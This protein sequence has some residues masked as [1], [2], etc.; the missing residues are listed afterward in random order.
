MNHAIRTGLAVLCVATPS[1]VMPAAAASIPTA[2]ATV[3]AG[4]GP[5]VTQVQMSDRTPHRM[6]HHKMMHKHKR[7]MMH[8]RP[9][10]HHP[11]MMKQM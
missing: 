2:T 4:V 1:L 9:M 11:R 8:K 10:M 3:A 6:M 5:A 7:M